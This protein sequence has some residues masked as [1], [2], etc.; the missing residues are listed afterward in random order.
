[1]EPDFPRM[2]RIRQNF[3][4]SPPLDIT[5]TLESELES[6]GLASELRPGSRIAIIGRKSRHC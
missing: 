1:M 4:P 2:L 3:S 5:A 6:Q